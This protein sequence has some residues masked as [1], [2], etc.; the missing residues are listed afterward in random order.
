VIFERNASIAFA[1]AEDAQAEASVALDGDGR[2]PSLLVGGG[3]AIGHPSLRD[4]EI[5]RSEEEKIYATDASVAVVIAGQE[6]AS[7]RQQ[8]GRTIGVD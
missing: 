1:G 7:R 4:V 3:G 2:Q 6:F 5:A 8:F